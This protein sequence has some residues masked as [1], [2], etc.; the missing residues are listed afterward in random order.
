MVDDTGTL[1]GAPAPLLR[2]FSA[3]DTQNSSFIVPLDEQQYFY[4]FYNNTQGTGAALGP[5]AYAYKIVSI[6]GSVD[7]PQYNVSEKYDLLSGQSTGGSFEFNSLYGVIPGI[8]VYETNDVMEIIHTYAFLDYTD[9][10]F[11]EI[12]IDSVSINKRAL[13]ASSA[14]NYGFDV[15]SSKE[16]VHTVAPNGVS[17]FPQDVVSTMRISRNGTYIAIATSVLS[18]TTFNEIAISL[19]E[20]NNRNGDSILGDKVGSTIRLTTN[21]FLRKEGISPNHPDSIMVDAVIRGMEFPLLIKNS[22]Y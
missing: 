20:F 16:L 22:T 6:E 15:T 4:G 9:S 5:A 18:T 11:S 3:L 19:F 21:N 7:T 8:E 10:T 2:Y 13:S 17:I 1:A 12:Y 14:D